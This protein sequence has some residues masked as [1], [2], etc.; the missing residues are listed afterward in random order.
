VLDLYDSPYTDLALQKTHVGSI[1]GIGPR[2]AVRLKDIGS[3]R[4][5]N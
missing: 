4:H 2:S 3:T 1:W 5:T